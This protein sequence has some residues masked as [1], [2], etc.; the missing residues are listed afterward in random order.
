MEKS[1]NVDIPESIFKFESL[2]ER[3]LP[4]KIFYKILLRG[5]GLEFDSYRRFEPDDDSSLIDWRASMRSNSLIVKQYVEERDIKVLFLVDV[6]DSMIFGSTEKLKCEYCAEVIAAL[7]YVITNT[8]SDQVGFVFFNKDIV[9]MIPLRSGKNQFDI[10]AHSITNPELYGGSS[11]FKIFL[12]KIMGRLD[13]SLTLVFLISDFLGI[14]E[15]CKKYFEDIGAFAETIAIMVRDPLD[16]TLPE[17][18][19]EVVIED[20]KLHERLV[21]NPK[22]AKKIYQANAMEQEE[23]VKKIF[24]D[25][26]IDFLSLTTDQDFS[27]PLAMFL[28]SRAERR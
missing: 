11:D 16:R 23:L 22:I 19:K 12:N 5:K 20:P 10:L 7:S 3:V 17:L 18:N 27:P 13:P 9:D 4:K 28:K 24:R 1:L 15:S 14:N 25:S 6:G 21:I 8:P 2:M 26:N